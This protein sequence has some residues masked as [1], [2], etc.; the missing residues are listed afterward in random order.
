MVKCANI[1]SA[2]L[3]S[4]STNSYLIA[5]ALGNVVEFLPQF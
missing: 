4:T 2:L 1:S 3:P 5:K